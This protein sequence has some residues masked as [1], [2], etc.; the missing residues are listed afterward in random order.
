MN[1][2][3]GLSAIAQPLVRYRRHAWHWD[4]PDMGAAVRRDLATVTHIPGDLSEKEIDR[5]FDAALEQIRRRR[6]VEHPA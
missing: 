4:T 1:S 5:R 3:H 2:Y 6:C